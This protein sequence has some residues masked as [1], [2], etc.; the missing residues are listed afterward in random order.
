M[1]APILVFANDDMEMRTKGWDDCLRG[2]LQRDGVGA[3]EEL[4]DRDGLD[5][6]AE[7]AV[8]NGLRFQAI[9]LDIHNV[10]SEPLSERIDE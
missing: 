2:Q 7:R 9:V 6:L 5:L 4:D 3:V 1:N 8:D 10:P